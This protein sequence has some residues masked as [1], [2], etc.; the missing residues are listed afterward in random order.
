ME[1]AALAVSAGETFRS[2]LMEPGGS[3]MMV[4]KRAAREFQFF[5]KWLV[6]AVAMEAL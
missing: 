3:V 2:L 5:R 1:F 4:G 6:V